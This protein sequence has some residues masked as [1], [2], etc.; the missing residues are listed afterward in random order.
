MEKEKGNKMSDARYRKYLTMLIWT[1]AV[2]S[3]IPVFL[4]AGAD[5]AAADDVG[6]G[7]LTHWAWV[8]THSLWKVFL[9]ACSY[10]KDI[11]FRWQGTW[12]SVFLF[13]LQPEVFSHE[14]YWVVPYIMTFLL[15]SSLSY[16]LYQ[17]LVRMMR[18]PVWDYLLLDAVLLLVLIQFVPYK[19]DALFWYTG[20]VHYT[21]AFAIA[22]F[23]VGCALAYAKTFRKRHLAAASVWMTLLGG[24]NYLAAFL[25]LLLVLLLIVSFYKKEKKIIWLTIPAAL[26]MTG[27]L[28]SALAPGN[29]VRGG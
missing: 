16:V 15:V 2:F 10:V 24:M 14:A 23:S 13:T 27:L 19:Q 5:R 18:M 12:F 6:Y 9:A 26:E 22:L 4:T 7:V 8:E 1:G 11:Y 3:L 29:A 25:A 17:F 20:A 21:V 28:I